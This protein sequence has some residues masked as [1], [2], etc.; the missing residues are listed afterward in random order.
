MILT[1][2]TTALVALLVAFIALAG[3]ITASW[4]SFVV[5]RKTVYLNTVTVERSKWIDKLRRNI[6]NVVT[7][8]RDMD[9][10]MYLDNEFCVTNAYLIASKKLTG[11]MTL[12]RLQLNPAGHIDSNILSLMDAIDGSIGSQDYDSLERLIIRHSQWLLKEEWEKVKYES[13][14]FWSRLWSRY[15]ARRRARDYNAFCKTGGAV[16]D[17]VKQSN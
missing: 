7:L 8:A 5:S 14:G 10:K 1:E 2:D 13:S 15:K 6:S 9:I 17:W 11:A 16:T 4:L 3:T 12:V